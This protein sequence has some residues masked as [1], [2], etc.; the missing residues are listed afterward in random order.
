MFLALQLSFL[1]VCCCSLS[2]Q[3]P[4]RAEFLQAG[5]SCV[6]QCYFGS[7]ICWELSWSWQTG[8]CVPPVQ[9]SAEPSGAEGLRAGFHSWQRAFAAR[10]IPASSHSVAHFQQRRSGSALLPPAVL[11]W[12]LPA[13]AAKTGLL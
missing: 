5:S 4:R 1:Q 13:W 3:F 7:A 6:K 2:Q 9:H 11:P 8:R 12:H 10:L